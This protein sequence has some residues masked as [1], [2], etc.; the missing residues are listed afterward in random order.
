MSE[1]LPE[2]APPGYRITGLIARGGMGQVFA[3]FDETLQ[4]EVAIKTLLP[5]APAQRFI[6]EAKLTARLPHPGIPP[7][8][9]LGT[10]ADGTPWLAMKLIHGQT[11]AKMLANRK[12]A[13]LL[14]SHPPGDP[15][16]QAQQRLEQSRLLQIFEQIAQAVGFA[17]AR[18]VIHRDLKPPNVMVGEFGEVQVMDWGLAKELSS[19][20][21]R[22]SQSVSRQRPLTGDGSQPD[23]SRR[24]LADDPDLASRQ[25]QLTVNS[26]PDDSHRRLAEDADEL[27]QTTPGSVLGTPGYMAPEQ[28]R[29][30]PVDAR[31]DVFALGSILATILTG[32]PA[33]VGNTMNQIL[34]QTASAD[35]SDVQRRLAAS[36]ADAE[37]LA[38]ARRCLAARPEDRFADG[39]EVAAAVAAYRA[40]VE[41]RLRQA[42]TAAAEALVREA[43]QRKRRRLAVGLGGSIAAVLLVGLTVSLGQMHRAITAEGQA[44]ANEQQAIANA[45]QERLAKLEAEEQRRQAEAAAE[46]ERLAK[47]QAEVQKK[48]AIAFRNQALDALR[49]TTGTDVEKLLGER[50][51]LTANE[52]A[53][54]EA[55]AQRWQTFARLEGTDDQSRAV[56]GEGHFRIA[57]LWA[58][59]G[60]RDEAKRKYEQAIALWEKLVTEFPAVPDYRRQ[61]AGGYNNLGLLLKD[62]G[63]RAEAEEQ[64]RRGLALQQE[65]AAELPAVPEYRSELAASHNN[66]GNLLVIFGKRAE[67]EEQYRSGLTIREKL[68]AEFPAVPNYRSD[69]ASS[70]NNLGMLLASLGRSSEA[71]KQYRNALAIREKLVAEFPALPEYRREL[72]RSHNNVGS[73]LK[74]LGKRAEAEEQYRSGLAIREKLAAEFPAVLDYRSDLAASHNN[75]GNLL[76]VSGKR[77]GAEQQYRKGLAIREKLAAEFPAVTDYRRQ[78]A[79]SYS[80]LGVLLADLGKRTEAEQ[81]YRK[82]LAIREKLAAEFPAVPD[83]RIDLAASYCNLGHL[84]R[85]GGRANDSLTWYDQAIDLLSPILRA[86]PR[87]VT[88]KYSLRNSYTGRALAYD[89]LGQFAQAVNDW[90]RAVELSPLVEQPRFRA[91]RATSRLKAGMVAEAV[92]EVRE[93]TKIPGTP[94]PILFDYA[95]VYAVASGKFADKQAEYADRAMELLRQAVKAGYKD[96]ARLKHDTALDPL[97]DRDDFKALLTQVQQATPKD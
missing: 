73:L 76:A 68:A 54:L 79:G 69:L 49:A 37:L 86:E 77:L 89:Q 61:L 58:Q 21:S 46:Q 34:I 95:C 65:L 64:Y 56:A 74:D 23:D 50:R 70:H 87:D 10:L 4:R 1:S 15:A 30:E 13:R 53:Y 55:I 22:Q 52:R 40:T 97:R 71:E 90:D 33:F 3:A 11:L 84:V 96:A 78:L 44:K 32:Q 66:L 92:A 24:R 12:L 88:V 59:L 35:L 27:V 16:N 83:H 93:L 8:H 5:R 7:V 29:A 31:A 51:E 75:L 17:H 39:R 20:A 62:L 82:G 14:A 18:G 38:I 85:D 26:E 45:E 28:A 63:K 47:L 25:R 43:E 94:A 57:F 41:A 72:A 60:R 6:T 2:L 42:E 48:K 67:A 36:G 80:N 81:Q 9:A 19:E 91:S